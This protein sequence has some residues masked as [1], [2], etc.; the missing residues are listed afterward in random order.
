MS[1]TCEFTEKTAF[2]I[3]KIG[4]GVPENAFAS[5]DALGLKSAYFADEES[6]KNAAKKL[7]SFGEDGWAGSYLVVSEEIPAE[8]TI[9]E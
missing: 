7:P 5:A 1:I 4:W 9:N 6:A 2:C 3:Q 8:W